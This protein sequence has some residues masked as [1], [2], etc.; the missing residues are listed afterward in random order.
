MDRIKDIKKLKGIPGHVISMA[1]FNSIYMVKVF[2]R[3]RFGREV[4][5]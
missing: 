2:E 5:P 3:Q 1:A 4:F